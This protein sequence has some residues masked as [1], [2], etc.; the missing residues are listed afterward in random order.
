MK[1]TNS[2]YYEFQVNEPSSEGNT[3][4][5]QDTSLPEIKVKQPLKPPVVTKN[6]KLWQS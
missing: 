3:K 1:D 5:D 2:S 4:P 6:K